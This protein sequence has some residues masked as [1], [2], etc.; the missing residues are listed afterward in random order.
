MISVKSLL[1]ALIG[2]VI[3]LALLP[4]VITQVNEVNVTGVTGGSLVGLI[5]FLYILII[6]GGAAAYVYVASK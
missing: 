3:G 4:V 6:F 2:I 5:P 1:A